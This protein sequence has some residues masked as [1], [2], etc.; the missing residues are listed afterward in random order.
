M[1]AFTY[2]LVEAILPAVQLFVGLW[3]KYL[4]PTKMKDPSRN[5]TAQCCY[6]SEL[7][8]SSPEHWQEAQRLYAKWNLHFFPFSLVTG[9]VAMGAFLLIVKPTQMTELSVPVV[10]LLCCCVLVP[11]AFLYRARRLTERD[12]QSW[13]A[14]RQTEE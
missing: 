3:A 10:A 8:A 12:L 14:A 13:D 11:A 2:I 1:T 6:Y 4:T 7:A 9:M 5:L